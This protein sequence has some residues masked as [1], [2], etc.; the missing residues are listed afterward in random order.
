MRPLQ[1]R[2]PALNDMNMQKILVA[3]IGVAL[4]A[5]TNGPADK[6]DLA[7]GDLGAPSFNVTGNW[8]GTWQ[9]TGRN[10]SETFTMELIQ[11]ERTVKGTATFMDATR[12]KAAVSGEATGSKV[13]LVM[14]PQP[15]FPETTW[16]GTVTKQSIAGTWHLHGTPARGYASTGPWTATFKPDKP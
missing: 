4:L 5:G 12:T 16:I 11:T 10:V 2:S 9:D 1:E 6:K 14:T 7:L 8:T 15:S 3:L 13:R